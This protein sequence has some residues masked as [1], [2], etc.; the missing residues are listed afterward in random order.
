M[1]K[2]SKVGALLRKIYR[3]YAS[4]VLDGLQSKGFADLRPSFLEVLMILCEEEGR[5]IK[6]VGKKCSLAKQ[7]MTSHLR[8]L[9]K[10][11][12]LYRKTNETDKREFLLY[13]TEL[14]EKFKLALQEVLDAVE[15]NY[16]VHV[17]TLELDRLLNH[18]D[19]FYSKMDSSTSKS[20]IHS[21]DD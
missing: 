18:L 4:D 15:H 5:S 19:F 8:E 11:G 20:D 7:T 3:T 12:Y 9:E 1:R 6:V 21:L 10:R 2:V 16:V 13:L 17:G 14:G